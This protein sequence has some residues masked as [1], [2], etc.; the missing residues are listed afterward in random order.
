[1][2]IQNPTFIDTDGNEIPLNSVGAMLGEV[3]QFA[4]SMSGAVTKATLQSNGWAICDGTTPTSQGI[5]SPTITTTP[6]LQNRFIRMSDD[7][8]SGTTGGSDTNTHNHKWSTEGTGNAY[9]I[10]KSSSQTTCN[11]LTWNGTGSTEQMQFNGNNLGGV[12]EATFHGSNYTSQETI[13]TMP[14][15]Y[16]LAFFIK[17]K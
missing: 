2:N 13:N 9:G 17:V 14:S 7:E 3:R 8:T 16:E 6:D 4:L 10:Q 12:S 11:N 1:M 15:Y 5:S